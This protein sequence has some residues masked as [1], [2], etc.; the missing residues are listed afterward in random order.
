[1]A[2]VLL[3]VG[4][5]ARQA[6]GCEFEVQAPGMHMCLLATKGGEILEFAGRLVRLSGTVGT[7]FSQP[8]VVSLEAE[9]WGPCS[10]SSPHR[11]APSPVSVS[12][13]SPTR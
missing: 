1:M 2:R 12:L 6:E 13:G 5:L 10:L 11:P 8:H 3:R 9:F 7:K 4:R